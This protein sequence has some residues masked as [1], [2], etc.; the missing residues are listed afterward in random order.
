MLLGYHAEGDELL[1]ARI[2]D[3]N[4]DYL[5]CSTNGLVQA[6]EVV[7]FGNVP[8]DASDAVADRLHCLVEF[9]LAASG[10]EDT[11]AFFDEELCD[12]QAYPLG[13]SS[14]DRHFSSQLAHRLL[15]RDGRRTR[16]HGRVRRSTTSQ[17][18]A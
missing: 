16:P 14:N 8:L 11:G 1:D 13:P 15:R 4:I 9:S 10:D 18:T 6:I 7:H 5:I 3:Y 2:G 17:P 12:G